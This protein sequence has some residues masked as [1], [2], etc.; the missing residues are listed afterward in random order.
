MVNRLKTLTRMVILPGALSGG[1]ILYACGGSSDG[2]PTGP[3]PGNGVFYTAIGASDSVGLGAS[4]PCTSPSCPGGTGW[5][6]VLAR[7]LGATLNNLGISGAVIG[8]DIQR[9]GFGMGVTSRPITSTMKWAGYRET[10][11]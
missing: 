1:L 2:S 11:P 4:V 7:R 9:W 3:T 6:P 8:P 10:R 5:V